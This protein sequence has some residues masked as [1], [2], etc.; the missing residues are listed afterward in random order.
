M[1]LPDRIA[2]IEVLDIFEESARVTFHTRSAGERDL[3]A[4][5]GQA[6]GGTGTDL[7]RQRW[8]RPGGVHEKQRTSFG[9]IFCIMTRITSQW[10]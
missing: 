6:G 1:L 8:Y 10:L 4:R 5:I 7:E 2:I 9:S 3:V